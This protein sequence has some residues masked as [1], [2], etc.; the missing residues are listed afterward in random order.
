MEML[1]ALACRGPDSAGA[2]LFGASLDGN[3][4]VR[5]KLGHGGEIESRTRQL[6]DLLESLGVRDPELSTVA[7]YASLIAE[8]DLEALIAAIER[9]NEEMEAVSAGHELEIVKQVG[10]PHN[11]E[12]MFGISSFQGTQGWGTPGFPPSRGLT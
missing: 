5:V 9:L 10:S 4:V 3:F 2:A 7:S 12:Q 11:L 8:G 1:K 6:L